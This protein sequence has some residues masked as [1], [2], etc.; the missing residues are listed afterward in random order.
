MTNP[1]P[2]PYIGTTV[3]IDIELVEWL[4]RKNPALD[5]WEAIVMCLAAYNLN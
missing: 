3:A 5:T 4:M 1:T 2:H